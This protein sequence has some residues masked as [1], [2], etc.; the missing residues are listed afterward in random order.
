M[1]CPCQVSSL[2]VKVSLVE[3]ATLSR[4]HPRRR[5]VQNLPVLFSIAALGLAT[6]SSCSISCE[7]RPFCSH[8]KPTLRALVQKKLAACVNIIP[9]VVS[10]YEWKNAIQ[11]DSEVLMVIKSRT[12]RLD[13]MTTFVRSGSGVPSD[14][15]NEEPPR[16]RPKVVPYACDPSASSDDSDRPGQTLS[17]LR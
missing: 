1:Q 14:E 9:N 17:K 10:V 3:V 4:L 5:E 2:H 6:T 8:L 12:L 15:E 7:L 11:T 16:K 13:E